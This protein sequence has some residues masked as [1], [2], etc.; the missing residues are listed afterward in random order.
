MASLSRFH[1]RDFIIF[2][3]ENKPSTY[4]VPIGV[5]RHALARMLKFGNMVCTM[6]LVGNSFWLTR[7]ISP[8]GLQHS[9]FEV[10]AA[11][12][13]KVPYNCF[14]W[15]LRSICSNSTLTWYSPNV[16]FSEEF[17]VFFG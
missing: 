5:V 10:M 14:S 15:K 16:Q 7:D 8:E 11:G 6:E 12:I 17:E 13:R 3:W 9:E 2:I 1:R 4:V